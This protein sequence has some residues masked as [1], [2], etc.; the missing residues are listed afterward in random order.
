MLNLYT[1]VLA[2][3]LLLLLLG[4]LLDE[5]LLIIVLDDFVAI[6]DA[7]NTNKVVL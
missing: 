6:G 7:L 3:L 4:L 2:L 5:L 1:Y